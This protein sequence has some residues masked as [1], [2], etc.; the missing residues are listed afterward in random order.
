MDSATIIK[1]IGDLK[2][3]GVFWVGFTG[4]EPLLNKDIVAITERAADGCAVKLFTTGSTL[5]PLLAADLKRAGLFSVCVSLDDW[6]EE[7]H[8]RV[9]GTRGA[10]RQALRAIEIFQNTDGLHVGVSAVL[11]RSAIVRGETEEL[12][13]FLIGRGV[14]EAWLSEAKPSVPAFWNPDE[15]ITED[16]RQK[17]VSLQD[18]FNREG[19]IVVNYLGHFEGKEHFGCNAGHKMIYVDAYGEV[20]PCV[21]IPLTFGNVQDRSVSEIF[22]AMRRLFPSAESCFIN[23]NYP[24]LRKHGSGRIPLERAESEK[25]LAD[26]RFGPLARFFRIQ[27]GGER[28]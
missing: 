17:L 15:V 14:Q 1:V 22:A 3:M 19:R 5:T 6:R 25:L 26:V 8:D 11:S 10:F 24:L 4:G 27:Y 2:E 21:F 9:R 20:S 28:Q 18:R 23:R 7:E 12:L 16:E 13:R